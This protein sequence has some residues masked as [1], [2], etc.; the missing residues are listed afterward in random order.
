MISPKAFKEFLTPYNKKLVSFIKS[1][2][3]DIIMVDTDGDC[4]EL[5][6]LFLEAGITGL[7]PMEVSAGM[8]VVKARKRYP[9]LQI[10]GG[11]PKSEISF[12]KRRIDEFL[13]S[14]NWLLK[15][16]GYIPFGDQFIPPEIAW[17][18]FK[19]YSEKLNKMIDKAQ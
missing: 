6:P 8:N 13:E 1:K 18:Y 12:G 4:N 5:I 19:Y 17:D 7:Y 16:G 14:V 3:V 15:Q 2:G 11:I 10:M 9:K